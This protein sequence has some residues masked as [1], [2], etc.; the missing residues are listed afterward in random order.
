MGEIKPDK[1]KIVRGQ[2]VEFGYFQQEGLPINEDKRII[3]I[4]KEIGEQIEIK[5]AACRRCNFSAILT[6]ILMYIITIFQNLAEAKNES[7]TF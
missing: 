2:T 7:Y 4:V 1:G 3:D 6:S 5:R